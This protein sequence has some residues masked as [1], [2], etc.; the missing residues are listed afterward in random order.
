MSTFSAKKCTCPN[1][2]KFR[3]TDRGKWTVGRIHER[4]YVQWVAFNT[5]NLVIRVTIFEHFYNLLF[6]YIHVRMKVVDKMQLHAIIAA[7]YITNY[8]LVQGVWGRG[9]CRRDCTFHLKPLK[10]N[11]NVVK[12]WNI[13]HVIYSCKKVQAI[14]IFDVIIIILVIVIVI[15]QVIVSR[16]WNFIAIMSGC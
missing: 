7:A 9:Q 10:S 13:P 4:L 5:F 1:P 8:L 6:V 3:E 11:R 12:L 15:G 2:R 16:N 14:I